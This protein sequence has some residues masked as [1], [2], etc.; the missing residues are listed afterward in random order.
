[1]QQPLPWLGAASAWACV[2]TEPHWPW[3]PPRARI[4]S[5][6]NSAS[7]LVLSGPA[8]DRV[9][10]FL[11]PLHRRFTLRALRRRVRPYRVGVGCRSIEDAR[12]SVVPIVKLKLTI[13]GPSGRVG[14]LNFLDL[15]TAANHCHQDQRKPDHKDYKCATCQHCPLAG[16]IGLRQHD[17]NT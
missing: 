13:L 15:E 4:S 8:F 2:R 17:H 12:P 11:P 14:T 16:G 9:R 3:H 1:M 7:P 10:P 6:S 5:R